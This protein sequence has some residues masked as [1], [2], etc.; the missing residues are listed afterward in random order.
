[1]AARSAFRSAL[2]L[3]AGRGSRLG[4]EYISHKSLLEIAG[5]TLLEHTL[6]EL[7]KRGVSEIVVVLGHASTQLKPIVERISNTCSSKCVIVENPNFEQIDNIESV[8]IGLKAA[9]HAS[10][11][12]VEADGI[13]V[14]SFWDSVTS[15]GFGNAFVACAPFDPEIPGTILRLDPSGRIVD[16]CPRNDQ[17]E[18]HSTIGAYQT[19]LVCGFVDRELEAYR[20][21]IEDLRCEGFDGQHERAIA[22]MV[23]GRSFTVSGRV[24]DTEDFVEVDTQSDLIRAR[25]IFEQDVFVTSSAK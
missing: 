12:I 10:V 24:F 22:L 1:M 19:A 4:L 25:R 14:P 18:L 7:S 13:A 6:I 16:Y 3:A 9:S 2:V 15:I 17:V 23:E 8:R 21:F 5:K 20:K 11:L